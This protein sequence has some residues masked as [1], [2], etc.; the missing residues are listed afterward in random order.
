MIAQLESLDPSDDKYDETVELLNEEI[1]HHV[2]E[3]E[4]EL[5]PKVIEAQVDMKEL[6]QQ[7]VQR[8]EEL[9]AEMGDPELTDEEVLPPV[10]RSGR[11]K[12]SLSKR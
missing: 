6:G 10:A 12:N 8:K 9:K 2:K 11:R 7:L 4:G 5:F 3:E 1:D